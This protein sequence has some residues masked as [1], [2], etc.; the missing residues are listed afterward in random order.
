MKSSAIPTLFQ[1]PL[2]NLRLIP[3]VAEGFKINRSLYRDGFRQVARLI[4]IK[5]TQCCNVISQ[6]L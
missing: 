1:V 2:F 5:T 3:M 4:D 6:Q